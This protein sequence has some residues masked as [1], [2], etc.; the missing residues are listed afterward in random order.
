MT[1][2]K[3]RQ[4]FQAQVEHLLDELDTLGP[5]A[6][7]FEAQI[8]RQLATATLLMHRLTKQLSM[9]SLHEAKALWDRSPEQAAFGVAARHGRPWTQP[10]ERPRRHGQA[11]S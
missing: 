11:K 1:L 3:Q 7:A 2:E 4:R 10:E 5:Q 6:A 8:G 9:R